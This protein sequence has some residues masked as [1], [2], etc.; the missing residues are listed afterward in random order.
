[1]T[2]SPSKVLAQ[3]RYNSSKC[4]RD[5]IT[6][7]CTTMSFQ[8]ILIRFVHG[9]I[10]YWFVHINNFKEGISNVSISWFYQCLGKVI[11]PNFFYAKYQRRC[12][13]TSVSIWLV[14]CQNMSIH[15][16]HLVCFVL[17]TQYSMSKFFS[18]KSSILVY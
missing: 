8:L 9:E 3:Q 18:P 10:N 12:Q 15:I 14:A 16:H 6:I 2:S 17:G 11:G 1:M 5:K 4:K 13:S 7:N